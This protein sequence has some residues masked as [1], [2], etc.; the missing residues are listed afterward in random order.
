MTDTAIPQPQ[1]AL[2]NWSI[3]DVEQVIAEIIA[4]LAPEEPKFTKETRLVEDLGFHSLALLEL[5][6]S[7]EDE[8]VLPSIDEETARAIQT[9]GDVQ[10][11]VTQELRSACRLQS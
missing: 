2:E 8:F 9:V 5:A 7:L 10:A 3:S 4:D 11:H 1:N 6:F